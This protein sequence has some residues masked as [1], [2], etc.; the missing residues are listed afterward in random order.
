M[1]DGSL[2]IRKACKKVFTNFIPLMCFFHIS[3]LL[4]TAIK[5]FSPQIH[6][7]IKKDISILQQS[8]TEAAFYKY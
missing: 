7:N 6:E 4:Q 5:S 2:S 1:C 8:Q 3:Q